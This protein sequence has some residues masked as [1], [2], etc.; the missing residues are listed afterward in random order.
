MIV[1]TTPNIPGYRIVKVLGIVYGMS[2]RTRGLGED[3]SWSR[4]VSG[5]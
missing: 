1:A 5:R 2:I 4:G 3:S